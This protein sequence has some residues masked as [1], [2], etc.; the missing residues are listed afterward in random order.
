MLLDLS[1]AFSSADLDVSKRGL[2]VQ[3]LYEMIRIQPNGIVYL[4]VNC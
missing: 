3:P 1:V 4:Q 2:P